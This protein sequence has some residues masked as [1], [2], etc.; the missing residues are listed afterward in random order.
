[1]SPVLEVVPGYLTEAGSA[2]MFGHTVYK[3]VRV[4]ASRPR[5]DGVVA[6]VWYG[7]RL[8]GRHFGRDEVLTED[9]PMGEY[10]IVSVQSFGDTKA[11]TTPF[12][13]DYKAARKYADEHRAAGRRVF[14][15]DMCLPGKKERAR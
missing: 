3:G 10:W 6:F 14:I 4:W 13:G 11:V 8:I 9:L 5:P 12:V 2:R 7:R 15:W 1:M